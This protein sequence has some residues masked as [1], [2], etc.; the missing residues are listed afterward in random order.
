MNVAFARLGLCVFYLDYA[1]TF[2]FDLCHPVLEN[3]NVKYEQHH[4]FLI[5]DANANA[6]VRSEQG[7]INTEPWVNDV[8]VI[9]V[10]MNGTF[11]K[12]RIERSKHPSVM[13]YSHCTGTEPG[14]GQEPGI[15]SMSSKNYVKMFTLVRDRKNDQLCQSRSRSRAV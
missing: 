7:F 6:D 15:G 11:L 4:P 1:F 13:V 14:T 8:T 2:F 5:F 10:H 12:E 3:T 9:S